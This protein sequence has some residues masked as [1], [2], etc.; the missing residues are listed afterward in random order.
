MKSNSIQEA[1]AHDLKEQEEKHLRRSLRRIDSPQGREMVW[2]GKRY[3]NFSSNDYLGLANHPELVQSARQGA[4]EFGAG[5]GASR[6]I[7]GSLKI[8]HEL[9]EQLAAFKMTGAALTFS[10]GYSAAIG[11]LTSLL[12]PRDVVILDKKVHACVVDGARLSGA[13]IRVFRH[14]HLEQLERQLRWACEKTAANRGRI[15]VVTES[16]FSMDGDLA[17]LEEMA[18][19]KEQYGAWLMVDEA[20]GTGILGRQGRGLA[21]HLGLA[22]RIEIQM[23]TLGKAIGSS[24]GYICGDKVLI[25]WLIN[26]ARSFIFSTAPVPSASAAA[27]KGLELL[28]G[29]MGETKRQKLFNGMANLC[30]E[31][32][33]YG[34]KVP[35]PKAAILPIVLGS[36]ES[37]LHA[38]RKLQSRGLFVPAIRY[39]TVPRG[40]ARLR[41]SLTAEHTE[42]DCARLVEAILELEASNGRV[43]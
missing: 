9:E 11:V 12:R 19:L 32:E 26:S 43:R 27:I 36:E 39:P 1:L 25:N 31:L 10:S 29:N 30:R 18:A 16:V 2:E 38:A 3:L 20:H 28:Q 37:T 17:L 14:N 41:L 21:D 23:G 13:K 35:R 7:S 5:S 15:L 40:E 4:E 8:H 34:W 42:E 33:R 6:L 24:G 22:G